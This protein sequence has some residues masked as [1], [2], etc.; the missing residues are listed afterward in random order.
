MNPDPAALELFREKAKELE[1][2]IFVRSIATK[3][4]LG[5]TLNWSKDR[6]VTTEREGPT[7]D[8][9][10]S[11]VLTI[12]LFR[13]DND[14]ISIRKT[15]KLIESLPVDQSLKDEY[16][17]NRSDLNSF[18]D[19]QTSVVFDLGSDL[20]TRRFL[21]DTF[22]YGFYSHLEVSKQQL[23]YEWRDKPFFNDMKME[24][25]LMLLKFTQS[26]ARLSRVVEKVEAALTGGG[27]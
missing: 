1:D 23:I 24:F 7:E 27:R 16:N 25:D 3:K 15:A 2:S 11:S 13:Q 5:T 26:V 12:R 17:Q 14:R 18:L 8:E 21:F 19:S 9:I 20:I 22:L 6:P 10:R 4:S